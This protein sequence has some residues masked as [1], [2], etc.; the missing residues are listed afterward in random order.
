MSTIPTLIFPDVVA[1]AIERLGAEL[2]ALVG[3]A[4]HVGNRV[5]SSR[6]ERFVIVRRTGGTRVTIVTEAATLAIEAW[7]ADVAEA[8]DLAQ[9]CR[10]VLFA[11]KGRTVSGVPVY[12]VEDVGGPAEVPDPLSD[13]PVAQLAVAIHVRGQTS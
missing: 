6:P 12:L 5:P 13:Q 10:S 3:A 4:V 2:P 8:G 9:A 11:L 1:L 7:G